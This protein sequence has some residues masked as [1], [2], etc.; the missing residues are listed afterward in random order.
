VHP[1]SWLLF[2]KYAKTIFQPQTQVLE[3]GPAQPSKYKAMVGDDSITWHTIDM[4]DLPGLTFKSTDEYHFPIPA[5][6]YDIV[7]SGQ[8]LEHVRKPWVWIKEVARVCRPGGA[9]ITISPISWPYH[10][11]PFDCWRAYP[12]GMRALYDE[13]GLD[14]V[15][16]T[17]ESLE[18]PGYRRYIPGRSIALKPLKRRLA[19]Q[20]MGRLGYAI[21]RSYDTITIGKKTRPQ[22]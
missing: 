19:N 22:P 12:E 8:V 10:A 13:A 15:F 5:D 16:C 3:I 11:A 9:V 14:V 18:I 21:E 20:I 7:V 17:F 1:N 4:F 6:T 2:D